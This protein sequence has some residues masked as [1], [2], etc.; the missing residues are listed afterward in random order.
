M[1]RS[2]SLLKLFTI[3]LFGSLFFLFVQNAVAT[4]ITAVSTPNN[5]LT[6][7]ET[8]YERDDPLEL[9]D[10]QDGIQTEA[11]QVSRGFLPGLGKALGKITKIVPKIINKFKGKPKIP[12]PIYPSYAAIE[13][14]MNTQGK[15]VVFFSNSVP[16]NAA[17]ELAEAV[18]GVFL[19]KT[20]PRF[21]LKKQTNV[22][23][24]ENKLHTE[25]LKRC[26]LALARKSS[27]TVYLVTS[28]AGGPR[29][30]SFWTRI[31][32][33]ALLVNPAV[34][35]IIRVDSEDTKIWNDYWDRA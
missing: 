15:P 16:K 26:S 12:P 20:L 31:E 4:P 10:F 22:D 29:S 35:K 5:H 3:L 11:T 27:G 9:E 28:R 7:P 8:F 14:A 25:F 24:P 13:A 2:Q 34:T 19:R 1:A 6:S 17:L 18:D 32:E 21:Y 30:D 33:P 23:D